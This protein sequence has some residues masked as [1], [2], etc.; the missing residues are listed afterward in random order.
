L[1]IKHL[2]KFRTQIRTIFDDLSAVFLSFLDA[3]QL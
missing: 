3:A 2:Q 1:I